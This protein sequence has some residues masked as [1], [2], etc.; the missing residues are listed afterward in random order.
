[1]TGQRPALESDPGTSSC[2][3]TEKNSAISSN[4][5][6]SPAPTASILR[7]WCCATIAG[8]SCRYVWDNTGAP[9]APHFAR[10]DGAAF[11]Q[12]ISQANEGC[13]FDFLEAGAQAP[14]PEIH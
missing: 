7:C 1:M 12:H 14:D 13:D 11:S 4:C 2:R 3:L 9:P 10:G 5:A 8:C 6:Q